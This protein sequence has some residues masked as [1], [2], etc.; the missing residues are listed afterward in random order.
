MK[1]KFGEKELLFTNWTAD[2]EAAAVISA[3][4]VRTIMSHDLPAGDD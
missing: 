4:H 2:I 3:V 1:T